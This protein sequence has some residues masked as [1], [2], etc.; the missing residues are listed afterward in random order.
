MYELLNP[1]GPLLG[2]SRWARAAA[3]NLSGPEATENR[4]CGFRANG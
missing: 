1:A 3:M 2:K 4:I